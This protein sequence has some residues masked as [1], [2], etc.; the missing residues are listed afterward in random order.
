LHADWREVWAK[1]WWEHMSKSWSK[2]FDSMI[3][4][5]LWAP[6]SGAPS[7]EQY[8]VEALHSTIHTKSSNNQTMICSIVH[9]TSAT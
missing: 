6:L 5:M 7:D 8:R 4:Q 2:G 3:R 1:R 9:N